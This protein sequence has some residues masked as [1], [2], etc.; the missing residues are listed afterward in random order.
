MRRE[1][2]CAHRSGRWRRQYLSLGTSSIARSSSRGWWAKAMRGPRSSTDCSGGRFSPGRLT[3]NRRAVRRARPGSRCLERVYLLPDASPNLC[4]ELGRDLVRRR[5]GREQVT[6]LGELHDIPAA[7]ICDVRD[8]R[9]RVITSRSG[10]THKNA[11]ARMV[12]ASENPSKRAHRARS[13]SETCSLRRS[14]SAPGS[15]A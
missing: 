6:Y 12:R 2:V 8:S 15:I 13:T 11:T 3:V 14:S 10:P 7:R 5:D 4:R 9:D 1:C